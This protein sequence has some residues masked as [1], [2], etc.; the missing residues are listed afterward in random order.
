VIEPNGTVR[1]VPT[2]IEASGGNYTAH[3]HSL[4]NSTYALI[5]HPLQFVDMAN[6]WAKDAV[7]DM[8]SRMVAHG[9]EKGQFSPDGDITR[10]EFAAIL[11]RGLGLELKK[12]GKAFSDVKL[13][14]G[15]NDAVQTA[16][17]YGLING[18]EDGSFRPNDKITRQQA[19]TIIAK[20]MMITNG[21][22]ALSVTA[23]ESEKTL[24]SYTDGGNVSTWAKSGVASIVKSGV[25]LGRSKSLLAPKAN[26][27]RAEVAVIIE[28]LLK[29]ADL[30]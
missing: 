25:V 11:V 16:Y 21:S 29:Q 6:H 19:M 2:R 30:I 20:A 18:F 5:W 1:H 9:T 8:G 14:D 24:R 10:G 12:D 15:Y 23:E 28:R 26:I 3:I 27:T 13:T 22:A 17:A 4:T 7:N